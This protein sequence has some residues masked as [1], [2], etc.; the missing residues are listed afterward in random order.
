[1]G[2]EGCFE[3]S[4]AAYRSCVKS[5]EREDLANFLLEEKAPDLVE[6]KQ[7]LLYSG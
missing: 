1:V 3:T 4:V 7:K 5:Q 6:S 2:P